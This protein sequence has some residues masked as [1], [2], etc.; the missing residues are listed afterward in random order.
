M[1]NAS[2]WFGHAFEV[3]PCFALFGP[4]GVGGDLADGFFLES[5]TGFGRGLEV[6]DLFL[7]VGGEVG[8]VKNLGDAGSGDAGRAGDVGLVFED[9]GG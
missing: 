2:R 3:F 1:P 9:T 7:D 8:E 4:V 6:D 5:V